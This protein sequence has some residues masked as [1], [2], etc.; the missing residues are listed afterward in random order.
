MPAVNCIGTPACFTNQ[1]TVL[2][3]R[4]SCLA[5][6]L[7]LVGKE[8][9]VREKRAFKA[10]LQ[11]HGSQNAVCFIQQD[12]VSVR[13]QSVALLTATLK[14]ELTFQDSCGKTAAGG[15]LT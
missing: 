5:V 10:N 14:R 2:Y 4:K 12:A 6:R 1:I 7:N 9:D 11:Y 13:K 15:Y 3:L 8:R